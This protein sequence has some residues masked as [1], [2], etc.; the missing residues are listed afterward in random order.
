MAIVSMNDF[1]PVVAAGDVDPALY[2]MN[3]EFGD[4]LRITS[5]PVRDYFNFC[6]KVRQFCFGILFQQ[7]TITGLNFFL[8]S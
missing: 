7:R 1:F 3:E 5:I 4:K 6:E 8:L 2:D